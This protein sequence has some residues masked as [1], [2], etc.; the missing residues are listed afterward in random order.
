LSVSFFFFFFFMRWWPAHVLQ[1]Q[2][3]ARGSF[4]TWSLEACGEFLL[5]ASTTF[6]FRE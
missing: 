1:S 3:V 5:P 6:W 4:V 2:L